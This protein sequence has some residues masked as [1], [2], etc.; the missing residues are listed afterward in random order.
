VP[1]HLEWPFSS[2][3]A[4]LLWTQ[5][6]SATGRPRET[7]CLRIELDRSP[8]RRSCPEERSPVREP[9]RA[10][11]LRHCDLFRI[12]RHPSR[13]CRVTD[14]PHGPTRTLACT[15]SPAAVATRPVTSDKEQG[16]N[17]CAVAPRRAYRSTG[18]ELTG[19]PLSR[20]CLVTCGQSTRPAARSSS[21]C[22]AVILPDATSSR[23]FPSSVTRYSNV[24]GSSSG[25]GSAAS[26]GQRRIVLDQ[27]AGIIGHANRGR[28]P[29]DPVRNSSTSGLTCSSQVPPSG[30]RRPRSVHL[31][32][33]HPQGH[34]RLEPVSCHASIA[35]SRAPA[36]APPPS[37]SSSVVTGQ[38]P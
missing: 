8:P 26:V 36:E 23:L 9:R 24:V 29:L 3:V 38:Q 15:T 21:I 14:D 17:A 12:E 11:V 34:R 37:D 22:S 16:N 27:W 4:V 30:F 19:G 7:T 18:L 6:G 33:A 25:Q 13:A 20:C 32:E 35:A 10:I 1:R 5:H 31:D 28:Y 2:S